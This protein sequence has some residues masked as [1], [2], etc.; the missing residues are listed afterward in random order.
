MFPV[1]HVHLGTK[2]GSTC[3]EGNREKQHSGLSAGRPLKSQNIL[4]KE[5]WHWRLHPC[6]KETLLFI[7][8]ICGVLSVSLFT[9][10]FFFFFRIVLF[11]FV[12]DSYRKLQ[13]NRLW[14][15][16]VQINNSMETHYVWNS[17]R[18]QMT[19]NFYNLVYKMPATW[20]SLHQ[21]QSS[22]LSFLCQ[23]FSRAYCCYSSLMSS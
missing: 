16:R 3:I 17:F 15:W 2:E 12:L 1:R 23:L 5:S 22:C 8:Q 9:F 13:Q 21:P 18:S 19:K 6:G 14:H 11:W 20:F 7:H 10:L 4:T